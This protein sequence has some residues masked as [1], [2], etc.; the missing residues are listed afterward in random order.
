M[1]KEYGLYTIVNKINGGG[2]IPVGETNYDNEAFE[3]MKNI[4]D[5]I[6]KLV[7]DMLRVYEQTGYEVSVHKAKDEAVGWFEDLKGTIDYI[8]DTCTEEENSNA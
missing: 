2:I 1:T 3:R 7:D 8:L 6:E 4:E 5:L